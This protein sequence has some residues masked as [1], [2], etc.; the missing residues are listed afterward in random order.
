MDIDSLSSTSSFE[1]FSQL[2]ADVELCLNQTDALTM[3]LNTMNIVL[4]LS[5]AE[6]PKEPQLHKLSEDLQ[7]RIVAA[8]DKLGKLKPLTILENL[9]EY[10]TATHGLEVEYV[11]ILESMLQHSTPHRG[12]LWQFIADYGMLRYV[13]RHT[14]ISL[15]SIF[16]RSG[17]TAL[18]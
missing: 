6:A 9:A 5:A 8:T 12:C 14:G 3:A 15:I 2:E 10:A 11:E 17:V 4:I 16:S 1:L 13:H 7:A 18:H